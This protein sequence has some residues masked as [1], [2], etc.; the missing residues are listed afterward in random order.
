MSIQK[1]YDNVGQNMTYPST[2]ICQICR[3]E[4]DYSEESMHLFW[5]QQVDTTLRDRINFLENRVV[6]L[7]NKVTVLETEK[8]MLWQAIN[9]IR[10]CQ[11]S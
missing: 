9:E 11:E 8:I 6:I 7:E 10:K 4:V 1:E 5:H 2:F 3:C